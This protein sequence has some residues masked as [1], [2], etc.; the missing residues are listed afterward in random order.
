M[1]VER[2]GRDRDLDPFAAA[3][4]DREHR[5]RGIRHPHVVLKLRHV[6]FGRAFLGERPRQHELG[7]EDGAGCVNDPVKRCRHPLDHRMVHPPLD[8]LDRLSGISLVPL[9]IEVLGHDPKLDDEVA[10]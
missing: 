6:F 10:G 8:V 2:I 3:R 7:L 9:P 1:L 4:D 5:G